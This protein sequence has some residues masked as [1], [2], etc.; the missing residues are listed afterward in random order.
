MPKYRCQ[1]CGE[2]FFGWWNKG[3]C[4]KC[5]G[6]LLPMNETAKKREITKKE[7]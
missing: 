5:G 4:K 6:K 7:K 2:V 1:N 3:K